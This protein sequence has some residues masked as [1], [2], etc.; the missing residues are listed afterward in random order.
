MKADYTYI[1][2]ANKQII[3]INDL[4]LGNKSVTNDIENV[5]KEIELD[6]KSKLEE[7]QLND[8]DI[9]DYSI[10]YLDSENEWTGIQHYKNTN[11]DFIVIF[12]HIGGDNVEEAEKKIRRWVEI[13]KPEIFS[14][15]FRGEPEVVHFIKTGWKNK[16]FVCEENAFET[17]PDGK[18]FLMT[19]EEIFQK[20]KI[21]LP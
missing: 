18:D 9:T 11:D 3:Y 6:I 15:Q 4:N 2:D 10:I 17:K 14:Y 1:L 20:F 21:Q 5:I 8:F 13:P 12:Y 7:Y 16:Y 19:K